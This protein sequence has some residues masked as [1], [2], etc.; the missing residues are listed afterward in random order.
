MIP[1]TT[2]LH[3][4][5]PTEMQYCGKLCMKLTVPSIGSINHVGESVN[6]GN[7]DRPVASSAMNLHYREGFDKTSFI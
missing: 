6:S 5:K 4:V 7:S 3:I 2:S 1:R